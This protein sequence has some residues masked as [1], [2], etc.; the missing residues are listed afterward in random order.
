MV[1]RTEGAD[2]MQQIQ[3]VL[4]V[5]AVL[6]ATVTPAVAQ[7]A[8][9]GEDAFLARVRRLT[10][11]GRRAGEGYWSP[12]G[13]RLV[14]QSERE[15][16]NPFYQIYLM[17]LTTGD[18][19]RVSPGVGKTTCSFID[20][21]TGDILFASTHHDPRSADL[22][23]EEIA[24]RASGQERRYAWDYDPEMEIWVRSSRDGTLTRLTHA[25]GYDAE[26]SYSPDGAWVVF[27]STR[28][29]YER[30]LDDRERAQLE[31]DPSW[32]G[33]IYI[34]PADGSTA[35]RRLT[36][37][38]GYDG[39]PFFSPDGTR[40][41][42][43]RFDEEGLIADIWT[44]SL[45]G[46]DARQI[47]DFGAMSWAPYIHPSGRYVVFASNKL[48]FENFELFLVDIDG[49]KEP[50]RVTYSDGF[51]GLPA[52]SPDGTRLAWTTNRGGGREG[53][54][55]L[56]EWNHARAL[57]ALEAAPPRRGPGRQED[58]P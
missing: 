22:Q 42:W 49:T 5:A 36:D 50:V 26:A 38:P 58:Q 31:A 9:A 37:V 27:S 57:A 10:V 32:F 55:Y 41:V 30:T 52:P 3:T 18:V 14:F 40:I 13:Q 53:Q 45:D 46:S 1:R 17:D 15:P 2:E 43:R 28:Q 34:M 16:G 47:T 8:D 6:A 54:I 4:V 23:A 35:P 25:R 19:S 48:G 44:M 12:D 20:P 51:D 56:A 39:G 11:E 29:A 24:F 33:E 21:R 7:V